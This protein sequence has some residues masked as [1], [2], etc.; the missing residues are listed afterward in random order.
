MWVGWERVGVADV[1]WS[2]ASGVFVGLGLPL[3]YA[4]MTRGL[5]SIVAPVTGMTGAAI[6]VIFALARGER[7]GS[8]ALL[9]IITALVAI[10]M[11]S[12]IPGETT[13][14]ATALPLAVASGVLFGLFF[15]CLS[16]VHDEA[17]LWPVALSRVGSTICLAALALSTTRGLIP[18]RSVLRFVVAIAL[19]EIVAGVALL[20][21]LLLGPV[22][23]A[24]VLASLYPVTTTILAATLLRE[25]LGRLQLAAIAL[26]LGAIVLVSLG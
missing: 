6:P 7:P 14:A 20:K 15:V 12:L 19:L 11:V 1:G 4:A 16:L 10:A 17:G 13:G 5:I 9:G 26:A 8:L 24:S 22:S 25:R 18:D 23:V 2:V 21:A 3:F